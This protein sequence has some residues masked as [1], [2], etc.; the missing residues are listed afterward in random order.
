M[1]KQWVMDTLRMKR[2][3]VLGDAQ[4]YREM[5]HFEGKAEMCEAVA[6]AYRTAIAIVGQM[7][8]IS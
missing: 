5:G 3:K 2:E 8:R 6:Q 7:E 1:D 4:I